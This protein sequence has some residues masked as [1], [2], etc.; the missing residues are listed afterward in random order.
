[1]AVGVSVDD[2]AA[3]EGCWAKDARE[4]NPCPDSSIVVAPPEVANRCV[5]CA[6]RLVR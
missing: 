5:V 4:D 2:C 1:M 6:F 3:Y